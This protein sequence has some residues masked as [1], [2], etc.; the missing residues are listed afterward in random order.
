M[1]RTFIILA[2]MTVM[3]GQAAR[4]KISTTITV[5]FE[6]NYVSSDNVP[7]ITVGEA[8]YVKIT[9]MP[10]DIN[11]NAKLY[12]GDRFYNVAIVDGIGRCAVPNL[13]SS[14]VT[15][16]NPTGSKTYDIR[17]SFD[18]NDQYAASNSSVKQLQVRKVPTTLSVSLDKTSIDVGETATV[19]VVL[20]QSITTAAIVSVNNK[21]YIVAIVD[22]K[23]SLTLSHL[24]KGSYIVSATYA[25]DDRYIKSASDEVE[26]QVNKIVTSLSVDVTSPV[27]ASGI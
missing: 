10:N 22:G 12:V 3:G 13:A 19:S 24:Q 21:E 8:A 20:D 17:A 1:V 5:E 15:A 26:L 23:G 9:M 18:G 6:K 14:E 11:T 27:G 25:G 7:Y 4:A 16:S 2:A